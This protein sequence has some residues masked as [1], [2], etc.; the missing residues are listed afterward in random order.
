M[1]ISLPKPYAIVSKVSWVDNSH[2]NH[3]GLS[4][5]SDSTKWNEDHFF[6]VQ[7]NSFFKNPFT[8]KS[9]WTSYV[10]S[11]GQNLFHDQT[12]PPNQPQPR[13]PRPT[14]CPSK[15][16]HPNLRRTA[17]I[18][19]CFGIPCATYSPRWPIFFSLGQ[20]VSLSFFL[21]RSDTKK[22][23]QIVK[24]LTTKKRTLF[25]FCLVGCEP[26]GCVH[27]ECSMV[28]TWCGVE[29]TWNE[30]FPLSRVFTPT[31]YNFPDPYNLVRPHNI[32]FNSPNL[33]GQK[34]GA[35]KPISNHG[36]WQHDHSCGSTAATA[37]QKRLGWYFPQSFPAKHTKT[38]KTKQ[39]FR[40]WSLLTFRL[41]HWNLLEVPVEMVLGA[42]HHLRS[43]ERNRLHRL[44]ATKTKP[45]LWKFK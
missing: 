33:L 45:I 32:L 36:T 11:F 15:R 34:I 17:C 2:R 4:S 1:H 6:V 21:L 18:K 37:T 39:T 14:N 38:W 10:K 16:K 30:T 22:K 27:W 42:N 23:K 7:T 40:L 5:S 31:S 44:G 8:S 9:F 24:W 26:Q 13:L 25:W 3:A 29:S 19:S 43:K 20:N 41:G 35:G 28:E 12:P